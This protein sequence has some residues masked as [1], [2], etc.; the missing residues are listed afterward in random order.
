V[1]RQAAASQQT[2][3]ERVDLSAPARLPAPSLQSLPNVNFGQTTGNARIAIRGIGFDNISLGNEGRIAY[4]TDG[5][6][7]S[8]PAAALANFYDIERIE[9][10]RGPQG[11]F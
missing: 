6:Y 3:Q 2:H 5:V 11:T 8:R 1:T 9:V 7:I 10:L 4:H